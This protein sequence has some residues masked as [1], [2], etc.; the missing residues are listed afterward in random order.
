MRG[1]FSC[2]CELFFSHKKNPIP[3]P[4]LAALGL[5]ENGRR[6]AQFAMTDSGHGSLSREKTASISLLRRQARAQAME[7]PHHWWGHWSVHFRLLKSG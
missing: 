7:P 3:S 5:I 4:P 1:N 2:S 6:G